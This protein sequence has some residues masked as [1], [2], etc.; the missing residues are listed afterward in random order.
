MKTFRLLATSL[1][2]ALSMG[3]S[4]CGDDELE[5]STIYPEGSEPLDVVCKEYGISDYEDIELLDYYKNSSVKQAN[6]IG[7]KNKQLWVSS[8]NAEDKSKIIEW[9][10]NKEFDRIRRVYKGYGEYEEFTIQ[11]I[12]LFQIIPIDNNFAASLTYSNNGKVISALLF[13]KGNETKEVL[14]RNLGISIGYDNSIINDK[15]CYS[16]SGDTI[17]VAEK[18][19]G[20]SNVGT[21]YTSEFISHEEAIYTHRDNKG[22]F[23]GRRNFKLGED[24]WH[25]QVPQLNDEPADAKIEVSVEDNSKRVWKYNVNIIH[26]DGTKKNVTFEVDIDNGTIK[27]QDDY[28]SLII[29]KWKMTSGDAVATHV[30]YKNDGTFEYTSTEDNSYKEV[31]KYKIDGNKLYEM[32][33]D[34][35]EWLISDIL[36]LNSMTLSV[37]ELEADGVTPTGQKYS[38]QRVE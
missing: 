32:F 25:I 7:L 13:K 26:Y 22:F 20:Y 31:G 14:T 11:G 18:G 10:D 19:F 36:L 12:S 6:F 16:L 2:V 21:L 35:E 23:V 3:V 17:C 9:T 29:G 27:G 24:L 28:A 34:E 1:L 15:C 38:Y 4:S 5:V 33:S 8:F 37:Q 30:T